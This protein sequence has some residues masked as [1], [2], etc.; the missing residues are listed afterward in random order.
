VLG[1]EYKMGPIESDEELKTLLREFERTFGELGVKIPLLD[2]IGD[3]IKK[4]L[5]SKGKPIK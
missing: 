4:W 5:K 3:E 2:E 1:D